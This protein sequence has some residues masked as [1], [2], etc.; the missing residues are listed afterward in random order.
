MEAHAADALFELLC[1]DDQ[2]TRAKPAPKILVR[3]DLDAL[4]RGYPVGGETC[5]IA[6]YGPVAVSAVREMID[7]D[8]PFLVAIA[9]KGEQV[10]GVAHLGRRVNA[11]QQS[12]LEWLYP[13]CAVEGCTRSTFLENDHREDW[14]RTK[15]TLLDWS[16]RVCDHHHDLKTHHGWALVDGDGKRAFVPPD[17]ARHP[18][19][20]RP[21]RPPGH[22]NQLASARGVRGAR[23]SGPVVR[24]DRGALRP[25]SAR[26]AP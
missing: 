5:E 18:R 1:G 14:A 7:T 17:D 11:K 21:P 4:L 8:D 2:A 3:V 12:A 16:D 25:V 13:T 9:T 15:F 6:G 23:A 26:A 22:G 20:A 10:L 24:L 19:H